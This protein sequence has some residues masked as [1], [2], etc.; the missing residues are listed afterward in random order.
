MNDLNWD[1]LRVFLAVADAGSLTRA[2][3]ELGSSQP[4]V[5]RQVAELEASIGAP[6][7]IR[8]PRGVA[9]TETGRTL[10]AQAARVA[11]GLGEALRTLRADQ[12]ALRG[13]IRI[14]AAPPIGTFALPPILAAL[15]ATHPELI[16]EIDVDL[17]A[18]DL[19]TA[20]ADVAVRMFRPEQLDL[21]GR[22]AGN[23]ALGCFASRSYVDAH[24]VPASLDEALGRGHGIIGFDRSA[25]GERAYRSLDP[26]LT[27]DALA[28]RADDASVQIAAVRAGLGILPMQRPIAR[29]FPELVEVATALVLPPLPMW[30]VAHRE[31]L[32]APAVRVVFDTLA[33]RLAAYAQP[34]TEPTSPLI[35]GI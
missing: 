30:V 27:R 22:L 20:D 17:R 16:F 5:G 14:A 34:D 21:V 32:A 7:V 18:A 1:L 15:R 35:S 26:R 23:I 28:V 4:T 2:A 12:D 6:L 29:L 8:S 25:W 10:A 3:E 33:S 31:V 9:L 11:A 13:T 24:G 19:L